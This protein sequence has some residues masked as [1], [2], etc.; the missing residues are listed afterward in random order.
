VSRFLFVAPPATGHVNAPLAI[1]RVLAER[2]H[3]VAWVGPESY[4]R[5]LVGPD[6]AVYPTGMRL[7]RAQADRGMLAIKSLWERFVV[8]FTRFILPATDKAVQAFQPDVVAVDQHALAGALVAQRHGLRWASLAPQAMELTQPF[9]RFPKVDAWLRGHLATLAAEAGLPLED[10]FD[11][12]FSPYLVLAFTGAALTGPV[13]FPDHYRL[14]GPALAPRRA[15]PD[16][17]WDWLDPGRQHIVVTVG[18]MSEDIAA[19]FYGR[20]VAALQPLHDRVQAIVVAPPGAVPDPPAHVLV[21][22]RVPMLD[23]MPHLQAVVCHGG[24]NTVCEALAHGRPLVV[25]PIRNDQP[26]IAEQ[27]AAAG[28]GIRVRF[29]RA[30]AGTLQGAIEAVLD[31]PGY[32]DAAGRIGDSFAAAGGVAA[33]VRHLEELATT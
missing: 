6:V 31:Q 5:P 15:D 7:Y 12:R 4:L 24:L 1:G 32:R 9:A 21:V 11:P 26:I 18:T 25:A 8:P 10:G 16:F 33:S 22:N 17:R 3:E 28:A 20:T 30:D 29:A 13:S 23:L 14:V 27:V 19:D 2:G